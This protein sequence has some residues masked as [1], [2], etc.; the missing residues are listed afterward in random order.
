MNGASQAVFNR[1]GA[2]DSLIYVLKKT[3][4]KFQ[5]VKNNI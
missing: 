3:K 4:N 2:A 5:K 1:S